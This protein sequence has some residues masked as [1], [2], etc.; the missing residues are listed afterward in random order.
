MSCETPKGQLSYKPPIK[1]RSHHFVAFVSAFENKCDFDNFA[2]GFTSWITWHYVVNWPSHVCNVQ[3]KTSQNFDQKFE[4]CNIK[5]CTKSRW[6]TWQALEIEKDDGKECNKTGTSKVG[7]I[8][9][10]QKAQKTFCWNFRFFSFRKCRIVPKN[11]KGGT[12]RALLTYIMLQNIK[13]LER[14]TLLRH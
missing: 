6:P 3:K 12:L 9:K 4:M 11:V 2:I 10:P 14:G 7:A 1:N 13:K 8:S 5:I